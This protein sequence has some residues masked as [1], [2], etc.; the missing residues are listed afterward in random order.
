MMF[1]VPG[2]TIL[3]ITLRAPS[4]QGPQSRGFA[5][6]SPAL[7]GK[8]DGFR[9]DIEQH[10]PKDGKRVVFATAWLATDNVFVALM[11]KHFPASL[12][13]MN[14]VAIDTMHLFP[15][16]T[17]CA[18]QVEQKY[19]KAAL[20]K[21]PADVTNRDEFIT[22]YGDCEDMDSADF[23]FVSKVEPFQRALAECNKD[24][25]ITGRRM[26]QAAQRISLDVWEDGKR[27]LNPMASFSWQD[28]IDY[29]DAEGVPVNSEPEVQVR[30]ADACRGACDA[31]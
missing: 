6:L 10:L 30:C 18:K 16:T 29:A 11:H 19:G 8:V 20:W 23:D 21:M 13:G 12:S 15:T 5:A 22:Q 4:V 2:R 7:Q 14:L 27:T 26:D 31:S 9:K 28:I 17:V 1:S 25:L 24:I 3:R